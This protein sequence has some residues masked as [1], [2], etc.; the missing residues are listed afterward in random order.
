MVSIDNVQSLP[1][2]EIES[3]LSAMRS[4]QV[5][6]PPNVLLLPRAIDRG[7]GV[8]SNSPITSPAIRADSPVP[9]GVEYTI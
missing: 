5:K 7:T 6:S 9:C 3:L 4:C 1:F 2:W 8:A